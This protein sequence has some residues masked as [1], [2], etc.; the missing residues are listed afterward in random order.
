MLQGGHLIEKPGLKMN[1]AAAPY[2]L[3][4]R[5]FQIDNRQKLKVTGLLP[6]QALGQEKR[7]GNHIF[8]CSHLNNPCLPYF[9]SPPPRADG[10]GMGWG[11]GGAF[12]NGC[13]EI[14]KGV[15]GSSKSHCLR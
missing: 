13:L 11:G 10:G 4:V 6:F 14:F 9:R 15:D 12:E 3:L 2:G 5:K 1:C 8:Q 7:E